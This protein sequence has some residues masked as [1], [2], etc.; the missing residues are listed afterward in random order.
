LNADDLALRS[1]VDGV[2]LQDG[3]LR[4]RLDGR[5][6][7]VETLRMRGAGD[8]GGTV[9]GSGEGGWT[10]EGVQV[11]VAAA[12]DHLRATSRSDRELT[13]SGQV[14]ASVDRSGAQVR[15]ALHVDQARIRLPDDTAPK[16]GDDV[17]VRNLPPGVTLN[18]KASLPG[19]APAAKTGRPVDLNVTLDLGNDL[20]VQGRGI[21]T[22]LAGTLTITGQSLTEPRLVGTIR[23]RGGEYQAYGQQLEIERGVLRFTGPIDNP[24]LDVLA[25][26]P[27]LTQRVGVQVSGTAQAPFVTLYSEPDLTEAEKLSWLVLGRASA[28]GGA[29]TALLQQAAV[30][31][32]ASR[33]RRGGDGK[34]IA[35]IVGLDQLSVSRQGAEGPAVTLGKRLGQ[36]LYAAYERSLAGAVGT[37]YV[38]YDLS[39]RV[40]VRAQAG[41]R[42]ALDLIFTFAYD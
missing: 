26:R 11:R 25:I 24:A 10:R 30:A 35:G 36:N 21:S 15:G 23:T 34:G 13:V 27:R 18:A 12:L 14:T 29:E 8:D 28:S 20:R 1:V 9:T 5:R 3:Q 42:S 33:G 41:E 19:E 16:L 7:V 32:L 2:A 17:V 6:L 31:L 40:T 39:R 4:A 37:L 38:Y 22:R